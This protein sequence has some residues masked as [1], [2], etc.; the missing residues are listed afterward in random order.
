MSDSNDKLGE[1]VISEDVI[2]SIA[3]NAA[4]DVDGVA[5]FELKPA[6]IINTIKGVSTNRYVEVSLS[7]S[8]VRIALYIKVNSGV[9]IASV[10]TDVQKSVK[11][12]VQNMTGKV[13]ARVN[14]TIAGLEI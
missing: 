4:R 12:A 3:M 8:D 7:D 11:S 9:N 13:V 6:D 1:L 14:V 10:A 5:G 2:A